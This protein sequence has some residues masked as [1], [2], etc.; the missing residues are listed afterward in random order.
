MT[1]TLHQQ[2]HALLNAFVKQQ[3]SDLFITAHA[4]VSM[5][6]SGRIQALTKDPLTADAA[7]QLT[8]ALMNPAQQTE[9]NQQREAN[10]AYQLANISRFRVSAFMQ[11]GLSGC[12]I[13]RIEAHIPSFESLNLPTILKELILEKRGLIL[14]VGGTGSGKSTS[15]ASLIVH[16]NRTTEG[17]IITIE[18]P[19]E[20]VHQHQSCIVTQREVGVD[21]DSYETA[22]KNTL[23]QAPDVILIGEIR[24]QD[25]MEHAITFAETGHLCLSTLHANN[26][27]Q[28]LDRIINF[29]PE[30]R[31]D[32]LLMDLSL[33]L[34]AIISQR[35]LPKNGGGRIAA[36]EVLINTPRMSELIFNGQ[37]GEMKALIQ[38]SQSQG[39]QTFDQALFDLYEADAIRYE[40]ALRNADSLND[41]RLNIKLNS[42]RPLPENIAS[43]QADEAKL[44]MQD[45]PPQEDKDKA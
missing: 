41:L 1:A 6:V 30:E 9:F 23:R 3:G 12:V 31:R 2:L 43:A 17:H 42:Q 21:T 7:R 27:N 14:F 22:L 34:R 8:L 39:M 29:F 40:D 24:S 25:T 19:I 32:Q 20:Y 15:L 44:S 4:P 37:V 11:Q 36:V 18:D 35:L 33:N 5:K 10:F 16:R 26:T 13:R 45:T 28:A 38:A